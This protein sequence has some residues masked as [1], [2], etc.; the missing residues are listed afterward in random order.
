[1]RVLAS[2]MKANHHIAFSPDGQRLVC[3]G[4]SRG[5]AVWDITTND[6]HTMILQQGHG[7]F[8]FH[9]DT[10]SE[11]LF[12]AFAS[13]GVW[14]HA[15]SGSEREL[16]F[17]EDSMP[18]RQPSQIGGIVISPH[19]TWLVISHY[20]WQ[21]S[22]GKRVLD[23]YTLQNGRVSGMPWRL[24]EGYVWDAGFVLRPGTQELFGLG[25]S[26]SPRTFVVR[27]IT[28]GEQLTTYP[29]ETAARETVQWWELSPD[30][31]R[32]AFTT[33][34]RVRLLDLNTRTETELAVEAGTL[35]KAIAWH[36]NGQLLG[37]ASGDGVKMLDANTLAEVRNLSW[38][39]GRVRSIAFAPDGQ[40]A[41]ATGDR[42]WVT[43]W[44]VDV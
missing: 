38:A 11:Q 40:T 30:G 12:V 27:D 2:K 31:E 41:A 36:P 19:G 44:D 16:R 26:G 6:P 20:V 39:N 35:G 9:F 37:V 43:L 42:G 5:V 34:R 1:M 4:N 3:G 7:P 10:I 8:V 29:F 21:V 25:G 28:N 24:D 32:V 22:G 14:V 23:R 17:P 13:N 18:S 15:E 33:D